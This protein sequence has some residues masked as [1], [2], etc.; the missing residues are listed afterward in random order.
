MFFPGDIDSIMNDIE[1]IKPDY[2]Q[3]GTCLALQQP[4]I[5]TIKMQNPHNIWLC[6][7]D[8]IKKWL[9]MKTIGSKKPNRRLLVDAIRRI[10]PRLAI[11]L[12]EKYNT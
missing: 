7:R 3:L 8:V 9:N 4:D 11:T 12:E 6:L 2:E 10:N 5:E 1:D